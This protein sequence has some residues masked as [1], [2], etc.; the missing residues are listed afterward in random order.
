MR[1]LVCLLV[2]SLACAQGAPRKKK[3]VRQNRSRTVENTQILEAQVRLARAHFSPGEIDGRHGDNFARAL[4]G[5]Q[6]SRSLPVTG[7]LDEATAAALATDAAPVMKTYVITEE[8]VAGP[9]TENI[10]EDL[11]E[12]AKLPALG[13]S[14]VEEALAERFHISPGLLHRLNPQLKFTAGESIQVPDTGAPL[15]GVKAARIVVRT[16]GTLTVFGA[17][18]NAIAQYPCSSG[19]EHD[20]LPIGTWKVT[21]VVRNPPFFYNPDLF[22]D[23]KPDHKRAKLPPGPNSPV[24]P[25]WIDI[26]KEH[27]G[28]H[29]TPVPGAVGHTQSHGCIRLTN[30]DAMELAGM[31]ARGIPVVCEK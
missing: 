15:E 10:P 27:Y 29:G 9:Y 26:S 7:E 6:Q 22:W 20:P 23:A 16:D 13:Y 25:V 30:W 2:L 31:V 28:I 21:G 3:N 19:S 18:N 11:T 14:S 4:R 12:Q 1:A 8:D 17:D 24:G 5:F